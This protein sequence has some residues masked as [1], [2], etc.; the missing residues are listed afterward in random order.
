MKFKVDDH[1]KDF[2]PIDI[3]LVL[4]SDDELEE[5]LARLYF[6]E[7]EVIEKIKSMNKI[8]EFKYH[9]SFQYLFNELNR[10]AA[11]RGLKDR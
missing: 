6:R 10:I 1:H 8:K 11:E 2:E 3:H 7:E 4:E 5:L 9:Q